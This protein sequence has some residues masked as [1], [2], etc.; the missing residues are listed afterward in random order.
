MATFEVVEK[1][2]ND[3]RCKCTDSG[4]LLPRAKLSLWRAGKLVRGNYELPTLSAKVYSPIL[5]TMS[6][7]VFIIIIILCWNFSLAIAVSSYVLFSQDI[8]SLSC[9]F[10]FV[11]FVKVSFFLEKENAVIISDHICNSKFIISGLVRH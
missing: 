1:I 8:L 7:L 6:H 3:L 2:G 10:F 4:L 5:F 9:Y 11:K